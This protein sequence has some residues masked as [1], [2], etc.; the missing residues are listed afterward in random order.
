MLLGAIFLIFSLGGC[1]NDFLPMEPFPDIDEETLEKEQYDYEQ[2]GFET[3]EEMETY[4]ENLNQQIVHIQSLYPEEMDVQISYTMTIVPEDFTELEFVSFPPGFIDADIDW[5]KLADCFILDAAILLISVTTAGIST[6]GVAVIPILV[7][8][9]IELLVTSIVGFV[10]VG[11]KAFNN[12][13]DSFTDVVNAYVDGVYVGQ[14][15]YAVFSVIKLATSLA[16]SAIA[17]GQV[18]ISKTK[19]LIQN[20]KILTSSGSEIGQ[21]FI[22]SGVKY[23]T[24]SNGKVI[25][26]IDDLGNL[27]DITDD[28]FKSLKNVDVKGIKGSSYIIDSGNLYY[29]SNPQ[30]IV[31]EIDSVGNIFDSNGRKIYSAVINGSDVR[32]VKDY[33]GLVNAGMSVDSLGQVKNLYT[34]YS[35]AVDLGNGAKKVGKFTDAGKTVGEIVEHTVSDGS[36]RR[37]VMN[38][39]GKI[40]SIIDEHN[41]V[42]DNASNIMQTLR[43]NGVKDAS[44]GVIKYIKSSNKSNVDLLSDLK[45]KGLFNVGELSVKEQNEVINYIKLNGK[46]PSGIQGHHINNVANHPWLADDMN[47][48]I[49][50]DSKSHYIYGHKE[51]F[52]NPSTGPLTSLRDLISNLLFN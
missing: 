18:V 24:N 11:I 32:V 1:S 33:K 5:G 25:G 46:M 48:I 22:Q 7:D 43:G 4:I 37:F 52:Q 38:S 6:G 47:N 28:I 12:E 50:Y 8:Y 20:G 51:N 49:F 19:Y 27:V 39:S 14:I 34:K 9:G 29:K 10:N 36:V 17:A 40:T 45:K 26:K 41:I 44:E 21:A 15:G 3:F 35:K 13:I 23:V 16:K 2:L 30:K 31:G 42:I